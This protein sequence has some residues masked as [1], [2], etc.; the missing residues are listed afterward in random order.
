M[1]TLN[2]YRDIGELSYEQV[3]T[4]WDDLEG[5]TARASVAE[6]YSQD[7]EKVISPITV[8][9]ALAWQ[10][11]SASGNFTWHFNGRVNS[12]IVLSGNSTFSVNTETQPQTP[13]KCCTIVVVGDNATERTVTL[14]AGFKAPQKVFTG[15]SN[16]KGLLISVIVESATSVIASAMEFE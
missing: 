7:N 5:A 9:D 6:L 10:E 8:K 1:V 2:K 15:V 4:N 3:D 14:G 13:G 11:Y 12:K 16:V